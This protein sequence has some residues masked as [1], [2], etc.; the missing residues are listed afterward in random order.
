LERREKEQ[1]R[2]AT[3]ESI[4]EREIRLQR[5][6][7]QELERERQRKLA[8]SQRG[9]N[10]QT[11]QKPLLSPPVKESLP[12]TISPAFKSASMQET[13]T[14][15][16]YEEAISTYAH[17]GESI[18]AKELRE[19]KEREVELRKRWK[20]MGMESPLDNSVPDTP[21]NRPDIIQPRHSLPRQG[22]G[23]KDSITPF[24]SYSDLPNI[25]NVGHARASSEKTSETPRAHV[26]PL[27]SDMD[28][29]QPDAMS[30]T[31]IEREIRL[32]QERES[33]LRR[34]KGIIKEKVVDAV[35]LEFLRDTDN[36]FRKPFASDTE[37]GT[38]KRLA[39][40]RLH[41]E[42]QID[43]QR[44]HEMKRQ[45]N[46]RSG[47]VT[48]GKSQQA[49]SVNAVSSNAVSSNAVSSNAVSANDVSAN[50]VSAN[51]M[52]SNAMSTNSMS[53]ASA[54]KFLGDVVRGEDISMSRKMEAEVR[55]QQELKEMRER[56]EELRKI[57]GGGLSSSSSQDN[58]HLNNNYEM[59][60]N[61]SLPVSK[62]LSSLSINGGGEKANRRKSA[63]A[64][65]W[66]RRVANGNNN[67][68]D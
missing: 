4:I 25:K 22:K 30:E 38:I 15:I 46:P 21:Y 55:I 54:N 49:N 32:S 64:E 24:T 17:Q 41:N 44:E 16:G 59:T 39:A 56:E 33:E 3:R 35:K 26:S 13:T 14:N 58:G 47:S 28:D 8:L 10:Q 23:K 12:R 9:G 45:V 57:H 68:L 52:S 31:P 29:D 19:Q 7:E 63:L 51:D 48:N 6:R 62:S 34:I 37:R 61:G 36:S 2:L 27:V 43:Q 66:E 1:E 50:D 53:S 11:E 65:E 40:S 18:I 67:D 42:I 20:E 60:T 5:E